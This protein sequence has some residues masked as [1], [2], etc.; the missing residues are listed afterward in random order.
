MQVYSPI[1]SI[2]SSDKI[3]GIT[4]K[5]DFRFQHINSCFSSKKIKKENFYHE[6]NRRKRYK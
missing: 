4:L 5:N 3:V 2:L 6:E 1:S